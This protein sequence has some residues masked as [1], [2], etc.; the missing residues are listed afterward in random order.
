MK[1]MKADIIAGLDW[2]ANP[3]NTT[4]TDYVQLLMQL[5]TDITIRLAAMGVD[6]TT[7]DE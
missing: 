2:A 1:K 6:I 4:A 3:K 7:Q 5:H